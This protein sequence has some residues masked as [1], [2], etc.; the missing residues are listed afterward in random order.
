MEHPFET[1]AKLID[2]LQKDAQAQLNQY[3]N[4]KLRQLE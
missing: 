4:K 2:K 3:R 1:D